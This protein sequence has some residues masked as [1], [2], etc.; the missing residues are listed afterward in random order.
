MQCEHFR[1]KGGGIIVSMSSWAAQRGSTNPGAFAYGASKAAVHALTQS[2]ARNFA[3]DNVFAYVIAP[4][5]VRS[6]MA[7][8]FARSQGGQEKIFQGLAMGRWAEPS[9]LADLIAFLASG[10]ARYLSGA[11]LDFNGAS[12][13]R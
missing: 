8:T 4:G 10:K 13:I 7:E 2:I 5:L 3:R 9:E 1:E 6:Q 12:Y 11:T